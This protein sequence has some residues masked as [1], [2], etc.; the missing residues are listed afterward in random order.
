MACCQITLFV[1]HASSPPVSISCMPETHSFLS[2]TIPSCLHC[3]LPFQ[4]NNINILSVTHLLKCLTLQWLS[5]NQ[6]LPTRRTGAVP[7]SNAQI[8]LSMIC[9]NGFM[10]HMTTKHMVI[11][12]QCDTIEGL[13]EDL[14]NQMLMSASNSLSGKLG[15]MLWTCSILTFKN[16]HVVHMSW[17]WS[18]W[19]Q[20]TTH[21]MQV[22][23]TFTYGTVICVV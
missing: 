10:V 15:A 7:F 3:Y 20:H 5:F 18:S 4:H 13:T 23:D 16:V 17:V 9:F 6:K 14:S 2:G 21:T 22:C 1:G 12:L 11:L 19:V 8:L